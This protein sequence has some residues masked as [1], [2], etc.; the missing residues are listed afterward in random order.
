MEENDIRRFRAAGEAF[1]EAVTKPSF[2]WNEVMPL[3]GYARLVGYSLI[4]P[5]A[6]LPGVSQNVSNTITKAIHGLEQALHKEHGLG[7]IPVLHGWNQYYQH[8]EK[9]KLTVFTH[10]LTLYVELE[11]KFD[12]GLGDVTMS[13]MVAVIERWTAMLNFSADTM[14]HRTEL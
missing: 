14:N 10:L 4:T 8:D 5:G 13:I 1:V 2:Q 11:E 9:V 3:M 12:V 6:L 7:L